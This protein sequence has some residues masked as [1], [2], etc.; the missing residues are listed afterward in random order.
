MSPL[1]KSCPPGGVA[2]FL[3]S[4]VPP[5][6]SFMQMRLN[7]G[8]KT[9]QENGVLGNLTRGQGSEER[10][11]VAELMFRQLTRSCGDFLGEVVGTCFPPPEHVKEPTTEQETMA[12]Q[13]R[14]ERQKEYVAFFME[15]PMVC[16]LV[17]TSLLGFLSYKDTPAC[18]KSLNL[19]I[20]LLPPLTGDK[21]SYSHALLCGHALA[22]HYEALI[23]EIYL[24]CVDYCPEVRQIMMGVSGVDE[25]GLRFFEEDMRTKTSHKEQHALVRTLLKQIQG[26]QVSQLLKNDTG[27]S[28]PTP[29]ETLSRKPAVRRCDGRR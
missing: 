26:V 14:V 27:S 25:V 1:I 20:R 17:F 22:G 13:T 16:D 12:Q 4:I 24:K 11:I 21:P 9:L 19:F 7:V 18:R 29:D 23:S 8:W 15:T 6:L 10:E 28:V 3:G 2:G 5:F